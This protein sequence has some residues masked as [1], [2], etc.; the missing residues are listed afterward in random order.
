MGF[1]S[2]M[3][4]LMCAALLPCLLG[5]N[6]PSPA[7]RGVAPVRVTIGKSTFDV[8]VDGNR[9]E[10][11]RLNWEWA[12]RLEAV[13]PRAV[14]ATEKVSGCE[15]RKPDGDQALILARLKCAKGSAAAPRERIQYD[16]DVEDVYARRKRG[17][18]IREMTCVP[19]RF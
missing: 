5:C 13:A 7:F 17:E 15:V 2:G 12:P 6:T 11:I 3:R 18:V 8:R 10:A 16:C 19:R 9:A 4:L 1:D 14:A